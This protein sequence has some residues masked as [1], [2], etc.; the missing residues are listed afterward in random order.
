MF[1]GIKFNESKE[2]GQI[3]LLQER[4]CSSGFDLK[5]NPENNRPYRRF[6]NH[7]YTLTEGTGT[8]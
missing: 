8:P 4:V 3:V 5:R 1:I 2:R 7:G 6:L